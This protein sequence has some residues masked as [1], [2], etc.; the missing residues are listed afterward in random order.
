MLTALLGLLVWSGISLG[1]PCIM[2]TA[3][4]G[5]LDVGRRPVLDMGL[6]RQSSLSWTDGPFVRMLRPKDF[7]YVDEKSACA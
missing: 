5:L 1:Q 6:G 7:S 4:L 2:L 3:L